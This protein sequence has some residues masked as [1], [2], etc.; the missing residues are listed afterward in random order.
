MSGGLIGTEHNENRCWV[1]VGPAHASSITKM[2]HNWEARLGNWVEGFRQRENQLSL[3]LSL[4][5]GA[6]VGLVVVASIH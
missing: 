5:V 4:V 2:S 3:V 1:A 6:L